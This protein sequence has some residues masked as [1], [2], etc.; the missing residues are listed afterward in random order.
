MHLPFLKM[1]NAVVRPHLGGVNPYHVGFYIFQ[2][3]ER[4]HGLEKCF[5]VRDTHDDVAA[6]RMLLDEEDFRELNF[7]AYQN[8]KDGSAVVSEVTDHDDWKVVRNE[9]IRNTG[10]N[11]I[12]HIYVDRVDSDGTLVLKH[13]HDGRDLD[14][15]Y[16]DKVM[17]H[18]REVWDKEVKLFTIIEEEVWEI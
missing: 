12:P 11:M 4:E 14:L 16:A 18:I 17:D 9:L 13:E 7:F 15:D 1:H 8:K 6:L 10:I 2:K 3:M 5:E